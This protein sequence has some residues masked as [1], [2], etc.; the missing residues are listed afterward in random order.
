MSKSDITLIKKEEQD[1]NTALKASPEKVT[2][3]TDD[4]LAKHI[5]GV[6]EK[7]V[8]AEIRERFDKP[9]E[10]VVKNPEEMKPVIPEVQR[11]FGIKTLIARVEALKEAFVDLS[12]GFNVQKTIRAEVDTKD[13]EKIV[14]KVVAGIEFPQ[15]PTLQ[16]ISGDVKT[17][18][19][20]LKYNN[21]EVVPMVFFDGKRAINPFQPTM[22]TNGRV[23]AALERLNAATNDSWL[24]LSYSGLSNTLMT[25]KASSGKFGGYYYDNPNSTKVYLQVFLDKDSVVVGT[26]APDGIYGIPA[27]GAANI[28]L[29]KGVGF[30]KRLQIVATTQPNGAT[31]PTTPLPTT[32]YYQ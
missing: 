6:I 28:E 32:L 26:T 17:N 19:P 16:K 18:I 7:S 15:P 24:M 10:V 25:M 13:I 20:L 12:K 23:A 4:P 3:V 21:Q 31:A 8:Q 22:Q 14:A 9:Q 5:M 29:R 2:P 11:V 30:T 27:N 1:K